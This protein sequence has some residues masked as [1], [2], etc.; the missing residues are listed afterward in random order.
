MGRGGGT[1]GVAG[2]MVGVGVRVGLGVG[3]IPGAA[4]TKGVERRDESAHWPARWRW[5]LAEE[6]LPEFW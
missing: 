5:L 6:T 4:D 2:S 3:V 1:V